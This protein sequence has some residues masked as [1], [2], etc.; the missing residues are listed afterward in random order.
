MKKKSISKVEIPTFIEEEGDTWM[1]SIFEYLMEE[2]LPADVK[3]ARAIRRKSQRFAIINETNGLVERA[4]HSLKEG[5]KARLDARRKN[6]MEELPHVLWAHHT[7]IKSSNRDTP[8]S[9]TYEME[10]LIQLK[11]GMPTLRASEVD[12]VRNDEALGIN[13]DLLKEKREQAAIREAKNRNVLQL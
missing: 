10:A 11:I 12:L 8:F 7:M 5:I 3:K 2:T 13:L 6:W 9:L 1:T 4:N